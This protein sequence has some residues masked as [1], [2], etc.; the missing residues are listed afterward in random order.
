MND[1]DLSN[2]Y[3]L[4]LK[5]FT[6][7]KNEYSIY[8]SNDKIK[9]LDNIDV[10]KFYKIIN[11]NSL[12]PIYYLGEQ[13][14]LNNYYDLS[15]I[16]EL[17]P[18]LCLS[19]LVNNLNPLKVGLIEEELEYLK[20]KYEINILMYHKNEKEVAS[21]ISKSILSDIPFKVIFKESDVDIVNYLREEKGSKIGLFYYEISK[22][23][24]DKYKSDNYYIDNS[25]DYSEIIDNI[26]DFVSS[27]I[28]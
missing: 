7:L 6:I 15:K 23:M 21:I 26:Y 8:L 25:V 17:I 27:K 4:T 13:Y 20:D 12:P 28:R 19:S 16:E 22:K 1:I 18:F 9:F 11:N 10:F 14:Y 3:S 2:I 5:I 24:K